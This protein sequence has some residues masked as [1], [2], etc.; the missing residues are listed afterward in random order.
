MV[1]VLEGS[2]ATYGDES[3]IPDLGEDHSWPISILCPP[4]VD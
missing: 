1:A 2:A 3:R 4:R